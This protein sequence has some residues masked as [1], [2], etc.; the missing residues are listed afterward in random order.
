MDPIH[1]TLL[2]IGAALVLTFSERVWEL[3]YAAWDNMVEMI[4]RS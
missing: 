3:L 4:W 1:I 2:L